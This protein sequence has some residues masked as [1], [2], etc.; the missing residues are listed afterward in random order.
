VDTWNAAAL[1]AMAG[2]ALDVLQ[3]SEAMEAKEKAL[4]ALRTLLTQRGA[5]GA[6]ALEAHGAEAVLREELTSLDLAAAQ[7]ADEASAAEAAAEAAAAAAA[8]QSAAGEAA[9]EAEQQ[10]MHD[11]EV[12]SHAHQFAEYVGHLCADVLHHLSV[13]HS[14]L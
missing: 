4:L 13:H 1:D 2:A 11:A 10:V 12:A 14:E 8:K 3:Q 9:G 7:L 6:G 5:A